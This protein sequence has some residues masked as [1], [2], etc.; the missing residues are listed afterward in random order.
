M[1]KFEVFKGHGSE[2]FFRL[3]DDEDILLISDGYKRKERVI[4]DINLVRKNVGEPSGIVKDE[5]KDGFYF[6]KIVGSNGKTICHSTMFFTEGHRDKWVNDLQRMV[7][8]LDV[9][10]I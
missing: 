4:S 3:I 7:Y 10:E 5:T 8:H 1:I 2:L 9:V 6:F